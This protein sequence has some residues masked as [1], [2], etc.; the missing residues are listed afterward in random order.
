MLNYEFPPIGGG[1]APVTLE[2]C[3]QLVQAGHEVD[4]VTMQCG[5]LPRHEVLDGVQVHRVWSVRRRPDICHVWEMLS[6]MPGAIRKMKSLLRQRRHDVLHC[7]FI[8]PSGPLAWR[9][10]RWCGV[11]LLVTCHGSDVPGY[12]P[13]RFR[14]AHWLLRPAWRRLVSRLPL[15][16]SPSE[17]L[18]DLL[19]Q[20]C[21]TA[22]VEVI[23]NGIFTSRFEPQPKDKA[24]L[25]CSRLLPR[26]GFQ[27]VLAALRGVSSDWRVHV[28]GDGPYRVAL[29]QQAA[30]LSMPVTFWGW[31]DQRSPRFRQLY[32]TSAIFAF[33]SEAENW[34]SVLLEAMSA[35]AAIVTSTA[36]G[37]PEVVGQTALLVE[38]GDVEGIR[39]ALL[40]LMA[41]EPLRR[42]LGEKARHRVEQFTWNHIAAEYVARY[43]R[44]RDGPDA[45][46]GH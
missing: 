15:L 4:V 36:G 28:V 29:E 24:I 38:P 7:H 11:P 18:R 33:P 46:G 17:S 27:H 14:R 1:A 35:G 6:F 44:L 32:E 19:V 22:R 10:H 2:L 41:D 21:P 42:D 34:P 13:D 39:R 25:L 12:N 20:H 43:E 3:K 30:G 40:R 31:L 23:P 5:G 37:C 8:F 26:K 16:I 9:I 45:T